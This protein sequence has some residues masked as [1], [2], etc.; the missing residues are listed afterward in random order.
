MKKSEKAIDDVQA[1]ITNGLEFLERAREEIETS[2]K[3]SVVS[4]WTGVELLLKVPLLQEHWTLVCSSSGRGIVS[5]ADYLRGNFQSVSFE[6]TC[7]RLQKVLE[8]PIPEKTKAQLK[9]VSDH[10]NRVVHFYHDGLMDEARRGQ[11]LKEQAV[12]WFALNRIIRD[13]WNRL[14]NRHL[15]SQIA[16]QETRL[17]TGSTYYAEVKFSA[18]SPELKV[19]REAGVTISPCPTCHCDS[20]VVSTRI[21]KTNTHQLTDIRCLVCFH[22]DLYLQVQCPEC[23]KESRL[24]D[25]EADF[26]CASPDCGH[27]DNRFD[28]LQD[29]FY[30]NDE[31]DQ[32]PVPADCEEC[33]GAGSVCEFSGGYL[34]THC[35]G[36]SQT[37]PGEVPASDYMDEYDAFDWHTEQDN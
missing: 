10:R 19:L 18:I 22:S 3:D 24:E 25:G 16:L 28:L 33:G 21:S 34:C 15:S 27:Q 37:L 12:A 6:E 9:T 30:T 2:P 29:I 20:A 35:F 13:D 26:E 14:E 11:I 1:L 8:L 4:F 23:G 7:A 36:F 17:L 32:A 31:W 5:R